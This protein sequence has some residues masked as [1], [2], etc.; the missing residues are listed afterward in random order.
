M[1]TSEKT[2]SSLF[3]TDRLVKSILFFSTAAVAGTARSWVQ[4]LLGSLEGR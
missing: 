3:A 1:R 4:S 2:T